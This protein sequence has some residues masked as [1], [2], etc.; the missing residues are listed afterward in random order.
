MCQ[1]WFLSFYCCLTVTSS[2]TQNLHY[3]WRCFINAIQIVNPAVPKDNKT[4]LCLHRELRLNCKHNIAYSR[5]NGQRICIDFW[6]CGVGEEG[7]DPSQCNPSDYRQRPLRLQPYT[8]FTDP[9]HCLCNG[10]RLTWYI[11]IMYSTCSI[12]TYSTYCT[13]A[14][15]RTLITPWS[16]YL[17]T[18]EF[19]PYIHQ[20]NCVHNLSLYC[21]Y[22]LWEC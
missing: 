17:H 11:A 12:R 16:F 22:I 19:H 18:S 4:A 13:Q 7:W 1:G 20:L 5:R 10:W 8:N 2:H 14:Y 9:S 15:S 6:R 3:H 21:T